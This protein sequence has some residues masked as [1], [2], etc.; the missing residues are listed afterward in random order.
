MSLKRFGEVG[1]DNLLGSDNLLGE[2]GTDLTL[3]GEVG[4]Y[5]IRKVEGEDGRDRALCV[6]GEIPLESLIP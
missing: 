1:K 3:V 4:T 6:G 2:D 5:L